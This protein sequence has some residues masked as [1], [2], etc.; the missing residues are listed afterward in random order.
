[1]SNKALDLAVI[2]SRWWKEGNSSIRGL[3][4]VLADIRKFNPGAYHYEMFNNRASLQEIVERTARKSR[5][6]YIVAHG[7]ENSICGAEQREENN[8][9]RAEFRNMLRKNI[10]VRGT[11]LDGL[12]V[13]SC[14]FMNQANAEFLFEKHEGKNVKVHW[15]AGYSKT[16]DW[17]EASVV[18]LFF[19]NT[20]Y[21]QGD[22]K[23]NESKRIRDV[24]EQLDAFIPGAHREMGFNIFVRKPGRGGGVL[25]LLPSEEE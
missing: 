2:E 7:D 6:L 11:R 23:G 17:I 4:D 15:V 16:I 20:Y 12:F 14:E 3:F 19:W 10:S 22:R 5:N 13:G 21:E 1:M 8:I 25:P 24:A 9:R 18:D